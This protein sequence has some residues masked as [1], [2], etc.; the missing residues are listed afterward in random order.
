MQKVLKFEEIPIKK[1]SFKAV[2]KKIT[3]FVDELKKAKTVEEGYKVI[4]SFERFMSK[5]STNI[6]VI[7]IRYSL[8]DPVL[9]SYMVQF[10]ILF[11]LLL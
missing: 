3:G 9:F 1:I 10:R 2:E 6:T 8:N 4:R 11:Q 5:F 7:S